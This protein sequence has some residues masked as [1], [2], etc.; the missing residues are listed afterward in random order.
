MTASAGQFAS[1]ACLMHELVLA[2]LEAS[3][4]PP[5][6][7]GPLQRRGGRSMKRTS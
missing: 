4:A 6:A 3:A 1:P 7:G 2:P 5:G